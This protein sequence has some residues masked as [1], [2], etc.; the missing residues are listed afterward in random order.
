MIIKRLT[1][2]APVVLL[3]LRPSRRE[4]GLDRRG[5]PLTTQIR[6][7]SSARCGTGVFL[8]S[9]PADASQTWDAT[10]SHLILRVSRQNYDTW[11]RST[12][13]LR[14]E[15]TTLPAN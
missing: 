7:F 15:G 12:I 1:R 2:L 3:S 9:M 10:L 14:F 6:L 8:S 4:D 5:Q 13:G 11:L